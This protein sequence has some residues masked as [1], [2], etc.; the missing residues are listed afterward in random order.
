MLR[1]LL[2]FGTFRWFL[3]IFKKFDTLFAWHSFHFQPFWLLFAAF[4]EGYL[5]RFLAIFQTVRPVYHCFAQNL[6]YLAVFGHFSYFLPLFGNLWNVYEI[7][8]LIVHPHSKWIWWS[9]T[10]LLT[11]FWQYSEYLVYHSY[12]FLAIFAT[13]WEGF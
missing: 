11:N 12:C 4:G 8:A 5:W 9:N 1:F 10:P 13:F 7:L 3:A 6:V 2:I